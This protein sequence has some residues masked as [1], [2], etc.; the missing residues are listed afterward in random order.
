M[1][2]TVF[3]RSTAGVTELS[4]AAKSIFELLKLE[5]IEERESSNYVDGHYFLGH[6][7]NASLQVCRSDGSAMPEYPFWISIEP[8]APWVKEVTRTIDA[9]VSAIAAILSKH[10]WHVFVPAGPWGRKDWDGRGTVYAA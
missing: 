4:A 3:A 8:L 9:N 1:E 7:A 5:A 6:A 2:A 10:G